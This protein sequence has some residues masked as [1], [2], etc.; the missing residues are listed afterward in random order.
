MCLITLQYIP[1]QLD[2]A[3]LQVKQD[4]IKLS[5][6]PFTFF[7]HVY[8][9]I[10][11]LF[12]GFFQFFNKLRVKYKK[13]H[14]QFGK[15]YILIILVFSAPSGLVMAYHANGG[16]S[17]QLSFVLLALFWFYFTLQAYVY[18]RKRDWQKHEK[19]MYRSYALTLSAIS[20][21]LFKWFLAHYFQL[22][23]MDI[24]R[25]VAWAGWVINLIIAEVLILRSK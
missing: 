16:W 23:P 12:F 18:A 22:P 5:Y 10:F 6:Y 9:S 15:L 17:A 13:L 24:Y 21:R 1:L 19:F 7:T 20:L 11:V 25:V 14:Q 2:V 4:E 3:F 8:S